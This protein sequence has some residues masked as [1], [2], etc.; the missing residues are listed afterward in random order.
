M[1]EGA[2]GEGS[3][4]VE[5]T[6]TVG[7]CRCS[8]DGFYFPPQESARA[9]GCSDTHVYCGAAM[10]S[11][12]SL[13]KPRAQHQ[14]RDRQAPEGTHGWCRLRDHSAAT[15]AQRDTGHSTKKHT[16][17]H[18]DKATGPEH[19][20]KVQVLGLLHRQSEGHVGRGP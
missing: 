4:A 11:S 1:V 10:E 3:R 15:Q 17:T 12:L 6:R 7:F 18:T 2:A 9:E 19:T 20:D 5:V 14:Q 8:G 13:G 16:R